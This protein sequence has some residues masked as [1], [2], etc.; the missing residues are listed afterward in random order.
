M[1]KTGKII[2]T[3][4]T[5]GTAFILN[6][7]ISLLLTPFITKSVGTDAYG[8]VSLANNFTQYASLI[9]IALNSFAARYI[10]ISHHNN[11]K[12]KSNIYYSSTFFGDLILGTG[13]LAVFL[14][15]TTYTEYKSPK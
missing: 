4:F 14:I 6:C 2:R 10:V 3:I 12:E 11:E 7:L 8:F 9:T 1:Q 13:I 5:S 15:G